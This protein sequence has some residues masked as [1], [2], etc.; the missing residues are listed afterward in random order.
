[1]SERLTEIWSEALESVVYCLPPEVRVEVL[2][3]LIERGRGARA[4]PASSHP[5]NS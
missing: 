1:M 4:S 5:K 2:K 3:A